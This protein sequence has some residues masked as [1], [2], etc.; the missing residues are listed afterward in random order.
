MGRARWLGVALLCVTGL[1]AGAATPAV[2]TGTAD[3]GVSQLLDPTTIHDGD[4]V[5]VTIMLHNLGPDVAQGVTLDDAL[6]DGATVVAVDAGPGT[7][8]VDAGIAHCELLE[9]VQGTVERMTLKV[10][11]QEDHLGSDGTIVSNRA[12]IGSTSAFDPDPANDES[13]SYIT[14]LTRRADLAAQVSVQP[15]LKVAADGS[16]VAAET[17]AVL[18]LGPDIATDVTFE[19]TLAPGSVVANTEG[20]DVPASCDY[21][22]PTKVWCTI[23]SLPAGE[24][25]GVRHEWV[26]DQPAGVSATYLLSASGAGATTD[27]DTANNLATA[28]I[29][30]DAVANLTTAVHALPHAVT[31]G[32]PI[33]F[34]ITVANAG[35]HLA[36]GGVVKFDASIPLAS[37]TTPQG[38]CS[39]SNGDATCSIGALVAGSSLALSAVASTGPVAS[40]QPG[41]ISVS[42]TENE[43]SKTSSGSTGDFEIDPLLP[44]GFATLVQAEPFAQT[45]TD[46][47]HRRANGQSYASADD[48]T[49]VQVTVPAGSAGPLSFVEAACGVNPGPRQAV[50]LCPALGANVHVESQPGPIQ[51]PTTLTLLLDRSLLGLRP[52]TLMHVGFVSGATGAVSDVLARCGINPGPIQGPCVVSIQRVLSLDPRTLGDAR[53]V[54]RLLGG[55]QDDWVAVQPG[56]ISEVRRDTEGIEP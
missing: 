18:N 44:Y 45:F 22:D 47:L 26:P 56:P 30:V 16:T 54:I 31:G 53:V 7:C 50:P 39:I 43:V 9:L 51:A 21:T 37:A 11:I 42:A 4:V 20:G 2:A 17:G 5:T 33:G 40:A 6:P 14:V 41:G 8:A 46:A 13:L 34:A 48:P 23:A 27:P 15:N 12:T 19:M 25:F 55:D 35:P 32:S 38:S 28:S 1:I 52:A 24:G 36:T 10:K 29:Q 3:L 49:V